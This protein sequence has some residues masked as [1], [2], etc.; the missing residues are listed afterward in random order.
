MGEPSVDQRRENQV[1][2]RSSIVKRRDF[3]R[4]IALASAGLLCV[5]A[6]KELRAGESRHFS[7]DKAHTAVPTLDDLAGGLDLGRSV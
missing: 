3:V 6:W 5:P 1:Q 4:D 7:S 2:Q